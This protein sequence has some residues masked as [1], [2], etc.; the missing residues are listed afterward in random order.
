MAK[1]FWVIIL[2]AFPNCH[3]LAAA[4]SAPEVYEDGLSERVDSTAISDM[5]EES[6]RQLDIRSD[7]E[8][9]TT[10]GF[11][12]A[13]IDQTSDKEVGDPETPT[14]H[15]DEPRLFMDML[16]AED[17]SGEL[18]YAIASDT[19]NMRRSPPNVGKCIS[20]VRSTIDSCKRKVNDDVSACKQKQK[21]AVASCKNDAQKKIADCKK[22]AGDRVNKC[23]EDVKREIDECKQSAGRSID[24]CKKNP[25][26]RPVCELQRPILYAECERRRTKISQCEAEGRPAT[27]ACEAKR[28]GLMASCEANR[29]NVPKCEFGRCR[30]PCCEA[31]RLGERL[32]RLPLPIPRVRAQVTSFQKNCMD[33][34]CKGL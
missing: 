1:Y 14:T 3:V 10:A 21:D 23:K 18:G 4:I 27:T 12:D 26:K 34:K 28:P 17:G 5:A 29:I 9:S 30:T 19:G 15:T 31:A 13:P 32:C 11:P 24:R 6:P 22:Q 33:T 7:T 20:D 16:S 8:P 2:L 25:L